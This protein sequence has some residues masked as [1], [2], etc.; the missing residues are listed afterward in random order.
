MQ[1]R[2]Q[3]IRT[4]PLGILAS[5]WISLALAKPACTR[6]EDGSVSEAVLL[7]TPGPNFAPKRALTLLERAEK[8]GN[9]DAAFN[10]GLLYMNGWGVGKSDKVATPYFRKAAECG[11]TLAQFNLAQILI[12]NHTTANEASKWYKLAASDG[13]AI[14]AYNLGLMYVRGKGVSKDGAAAKK[15]FGQA[16]AAGHVNAMYNLGYMYDDT[17]GT[18][19]DYR[20]AFRYYS[21]AAERNHA[22]AQTRLAVMYGLGRG[23]PKDHNAALLWLQRATSNSDTDA[24][25]ILRTS[26][27]GAAAEGAR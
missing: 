15:Y 20:Q 12:E 7:M 2:Q 26:G 8:A 10:Q 25:A 5:F 11:H 4:I 1:T 19:P 6:N 9:V 27:R 13:H 3:V 14:S 16:A 18:Q 17:E 24:A 23:V 21:Q 22:A